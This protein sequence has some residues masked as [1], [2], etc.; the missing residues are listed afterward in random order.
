M[1]T[2]TKLYWWFK[3]IRWPMQIYKNGPNLQHWQHQM[4]KSLIASRHT[5]FSATLKDSV[6]FKNTGNS[7]LIML[8]L[9]TEKEPK[10][11]R[12][13][14]ESQCSRNRD[15][16]IERHFDSASINCVKILSTWKL[17]SST[18]LRSS[19]VHSFCNM[20]NLFHKTTREPTN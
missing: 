20:N 12:Q 17:K 2:N 11:F 13:Q 8:F 1:N 5:A 3:I 18:A 10:W 6:S 19:M 7:Q 16:K 9:E 14:S 15:S 4:E